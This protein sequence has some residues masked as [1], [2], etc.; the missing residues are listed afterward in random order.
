[1]F[2]NTISSTYMSQL[3]PVASNR[4]DEL[5]LLTSLYLQS[6]VNFWSFEFNV[7]AYPLSID[8]SNFFATFNKFIAINAE[9]LAISSYTNGLANY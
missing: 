1:M 8:A 5:Y 9:F 4:Y 3:N 7:A 6:N 2:D